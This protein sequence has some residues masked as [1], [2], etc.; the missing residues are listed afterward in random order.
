MDWVSIIAEATEEEAK[1][2]GD[3]VVNRRDKRFDEIRH[4]VH[5]PTR[6]QAACIAVPEMVPQA[7]RLHCQF[8]P[9][10]SVVL[11]SRA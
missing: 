5:T 11:H 7:Q 4:P 1:C 6:R 2:C 10:L 8:I 9:L 3:A